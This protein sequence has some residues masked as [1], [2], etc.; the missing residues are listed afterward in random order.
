MAEKEDPEK[1]KSG[2]ESQQGRIP[3]ATGMV[4]GEGEHVRFIARIKYTSQVEV[5]LH[6]VEESMYDSVR[7]GIYNAQDAL[8]TLQ[9]SVPPGVSP[10][11]HQRPEAAGSSPMQ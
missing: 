7:N 5:F 2:R 10:R 8:I 6:W 9:A 1:P 11:R 4:S 3:D